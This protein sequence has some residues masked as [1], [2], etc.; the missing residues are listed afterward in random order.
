MSNKRKYQYHKDGTL[1]EN[2][3]EY[4]FVF[5]SNTRGIH[6]KG[7]ALV[8]KNKF[9]A[10]YGV[11]VGITGNSYAIPT[12]DHFL[13]TLP[14]EKIKHYINIFKDFTHNNPDLKFWVTSVGCGLAG[15]TAA[16]IAPYFKGCNTNCNFPHT[17]ISYL[18]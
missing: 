18:E 12:K 1:P 14:L 3:S 6:G 5:G 2:L 7:A 10:E 4:K 8:A 11:G 17:W 16:Q 9:G 15:Y 13:R